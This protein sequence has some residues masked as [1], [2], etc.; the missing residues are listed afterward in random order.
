MTPKIGVPAGEPRHVDMVGSAT[1]NVSG[2]A[3][4]AAAASVDE[5]NVDDV[6]DDVM[7]CAMMCHVTV[8]SDSMTHDTHQPLTIRQQLIGCKQCLHMSL[9]LLPPCP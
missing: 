9:L 4:A 6:D 3:T 8:A 1:V 7:D 5:D 2:S